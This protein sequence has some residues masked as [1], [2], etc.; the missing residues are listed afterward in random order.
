MSG[1][2][3]CFL[4]H[5]RPPL[6]ISLSHNTTFRHLPRLF[7]RAKATRPPAPDPNPKATRP[8]PP[9][10]PSAQSIS[11]TRPNRR[12]FPPAC[13]KIT[14]TRVACNA[15]ARRGSRVSARPSRAEKKASHAIPAVNFAGAPRSQYGKLIT[16]RKAPSASQRSA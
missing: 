16:E 9:S 5:L 4:N 11:I 6:N 13:K 14:R 12:R 1:F 8:H 2:H 15:P 10:N 3:Y 7:I